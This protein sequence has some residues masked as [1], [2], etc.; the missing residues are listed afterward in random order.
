MKT[1]SKIKSIEPV[2]IQEVFDITVDNVHSYLANNIWNHNSSSEPNIQQIPKTSVDPNIKKQLIARPGTL[3]LASDF[4]Q[5]ELRIMAH[6]SGDE[7]YLNAFAS[8]QDP[9]LA[10]A[11]K[12]YGVDYDEIL[13]IHDDEKHPDHKLWKTRRKQAKQLAFGLIYG[14]GAALLA[15]KLSD[16]KAGLIVSKE[17][18]QKQMDEFF[19][20]HP[21]LRTFKAKQERFLRKHGYLKSLFGRKRRLPE[22]YSGDK[23]Q[24]AYAIRMSLN[25]PVQSAASDMCLFGSILIYYLMRQEHL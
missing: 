7:T 17:E 5:A 11:C 4:S 3:Y 10:I 19:D 18:A 23:Q 6:L 25:F 21:K 1:Y 24:E 16:P 2:G 20:E 13:K 15:V 8:G 14:I 22:I 9:H 12:K